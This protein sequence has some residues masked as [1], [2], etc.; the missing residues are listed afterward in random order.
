[1]HITKCKNACWKNSGT[2]L[3]KEGVYLHFFVKK[4]HINLKSA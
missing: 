3:S 2:R 1:M 4:H